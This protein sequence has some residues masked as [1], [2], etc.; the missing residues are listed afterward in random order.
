MVIQCVQ[1]AHITGAIDI[2]PVTLLILIGGVGGH[3]IDGSNDG[4]LL[5][6]VQPHH[7]VAGLTTGGVTG[8]TNLGLVNIIQGLDIAD[9]G[10]SAIGIADGV[11]GEIGFGTHNLR[12][13]MV[14]HIRHDD[15]K[16]PAGQLHAVLGIAFL[17]DRQAVGENDGGGRMLRRGAVGLIDAGSHLAAGGG[18][19]LHV[20]DAYL[21]PVPQQT[22]GQSGKHQG[23]HQ[24]EYQ[25]DSC[26]AFTFFHFLLSFF[27]M[28]C[29]PFLLGSPVAILLNHPPVR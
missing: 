24:C 17:V 16:A 18:F 2:G 19:Q 4:S 29:T 26:R 10:I 7:I 12:I 28:N 25:T 15:H 22:G 8:N 14:Q 23:K 6:I 21:A 20:G 9:A 11:G 27:G 1:K 13:A 3:Q 5:G